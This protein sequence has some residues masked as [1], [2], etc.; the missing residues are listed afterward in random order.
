MRRIILL[1]VP[2]V[3]MTTGCANLSPPSPTS[4]SLSPPRIYRPIY[5]GTET[6]GYSGAKAGSEVIIVA[7][8]NEQLGK[9]IAPPWGWGTVRTRRALEIR[10]K[11]TAI[12]SHDED[13]SYP[14]WDQDAVMVE[15]IPSDG[16]IN[17]E[18]LNPPT[19]VGPIYHCQRAARVRDLVE[20]VRLSHKKSGATP[21]T[22]GPWT[23]YPAGPIMIMT[24]FEENEEFKVKQNNPTVQES[25]Y[26]PPMFVLP[27]LETLDDPKYKPRI[28]E[29]VSVGATVVKVCNLTTGATVSIYTL[30]PDTNEKMDEIANGIANTEC[31]LCRVEPL[32]TNKIKAQQALCELKSPPSDPVKPK[33]SINI[34]RIAEPICPRATNI[35]V[36]DTQF[37]AFVAIRVNG[38]DR[39]HV[40]APGTTTLVGIGGGVPLKTGDKITVRQY[41]TPAVTSSWSAPITVS[42]PIAVVSHP[43]AVF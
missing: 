31:S 24:H 14:T 42:G 3:I 26:S 20:G 36:H 11:I 12:Q 10:E 25:E 5:Q 43:V 41:T 27:K 39:G 13:V 9:G 18:K 22:A 4:S 16:L 37:G 23:P 21:D 32:M 1:L 35:I 34:P 17:G 33:S 29:N 40:S 2:L 30:D 6:V 8:D 7:N 28:D 19:V 15:A 38:E